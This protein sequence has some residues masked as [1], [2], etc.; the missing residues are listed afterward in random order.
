M[1]YLQSSASASSKDVGRWKA[2]DDLAL[3]T[4]VQQVLYIHRIIKVCF[5]SQRVQFTAKMKF[6]DEKQSNESKCK[7]MFIFLYCTYA[8]Y[9]T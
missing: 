3:I 2:Q 9:S 8:Y 7:L 1:F 6:E 5:S 4:A